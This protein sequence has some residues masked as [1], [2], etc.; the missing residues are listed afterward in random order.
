[1][2]KR[3]V[4]VIGWDA[5]DWK[6]IDP[7]MDAGMMPNLERMVNSGVR[8]RLA[9]LDP[10][11]SPMLWTS[12]AT[13]KRPYK[14]GILGFTETGPDGKTLRP[15]T[16]THRRVKAIWNILTQVGKRTHVLG[17]WPSHP[18]EPINGVMVSNFYQ[19]AEKPINEPWP[20]RAG[21]VHP[22][23][24][25]GEF[26]DLRIHPAEL[27]SA[28]IAPFVPGYEQV[29]QDKEDGLSSIARILADCS[30]VHAA[31]TYV[32]EREEWDLVGV[33]YDAIDH[34]KHGF[35]KFHPPRRPYIPEREFNLYKGVVTAAYR[36]HDLM[37]GRLLDLAGEEAT[38]LLLS[39][40]GFHPDHLRPGAL[41]REPAAPAYEHSPYG[42][43]CIKGPGIKQDELVHGASLLDITPTL[44]TLFG[45]PTAKDM[46]GRPL[47][48][49]F[50]DPPELN[51]I[52]S[53]ELVEG[54]CGMHPRNQAA[55]AV[56]DM[57]RESL[58]QLVDLGYVEDP[59]EDMEQ[60]SVRT[61]RE[62][63]YFLARSYVDGGRH[64]E[65]LAILED[66]FA[67]APDQLRY[68][69]Q[70][71]QS[72]LRLARTAEA[73]ITLEHTRTARAAAHAEERRKML[74]APAPTVKA[75]AAPPK[76]P[77]PYREEPALRMLE[78]TVLLAEQR[79]DEAVALLER[80]SL[81]HIF[82]ER[83]QLRLGNALL[84]AQQWQRAMLA[85]ERAIAHDVQAD[86]AYYG[87]GLAHLRNGDAE[88][89]AGEFLRCI[90]LN[91]HRPFA[92]YHL[93][94]AYA[95][96]GRYTDSV[97]AYEVCLKMAPGINKARLHLA[98]LYEEHLNDPDKAK[99]LRAEVS[100]RS[101]PNII[102]VV[103]GLPRS[104]T[105][106]MMQALVAAG[107]TPYMDGKRSPDESNPNGYLEHDS[108]KSLARDAR[109]LEQAQG[110]VVKVV[111][112]LLPYLQPRFHYK[113]IFMERELD[114]VIA[115][116]RRMLARDGKDK[117]AVTYPLGLHNA[118]K[119]QLRKVERWQE[120]CPNVE[121]IRLHYGEVIKEPHTAMERVGKFLGKQLDLDAMAI[122]V[123]PE[124]Y[125]EKSRTSSGHLGQD[126]VP[127]AGE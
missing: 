101:A 36:F 59:G 91:F 14:H 83:V 90:G 105:S 99:V 123:H 102:T 57:D 98:R 16:N 80:M 46:D 3:K 104:G 125:R 40:H 117:Q 4:L 61:V 122:A 103:S 95:Q 79:T 29:D 41:P 2:G 88:R 42:I 94:E 78:T 106:M 97:H 45:L 19:H 67:A 34:F 58:R 1:M 37:L 43:F 33:Y 124:L 73:R 6:A 93:G 55:D 92:H 48:E 96:L 5:A 51:V 76:D 74:A 87:L 63:R 39:D 38:V 100:E 84:K 68:G 47:L 15:V 54:E 10:P 72:Q 82:G 118:Y 75:V 31:A 114:E 86:H 85:F 26:A 44:L 107:L 35:M 9:T 8:G 116:Q 121:M 69:L 50:T 17:W 30:T 111:A 108:V 70:L 28:H 126:E 56:S 27:T 49:V 53:W 20:M 110:K 115:S 112:P 52:P 120:Q 24:R 127:P 113:V 22:A 21:T 66:L 23:E 81:E 11:L 65:A 77:G 119:E 32:L 64:L 89:A 109:F 18:A 7:L 71:A 62:N 12:I 13:G 25:S 60:A